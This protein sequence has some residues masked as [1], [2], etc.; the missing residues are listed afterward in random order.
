[1]ACKCF[2]ILIGLFHQ[3]IKTTKSSKVLAWSRLRIFLKVTHQDEVEQESEKSLR[4]GLRNFDVS[5]KNYDGALE[6]LWR[7]RAPESP[8]STGLLRKTGFI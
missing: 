7:S 3:P 6:V 1:M 4:Y 8:L 2:S 5:L